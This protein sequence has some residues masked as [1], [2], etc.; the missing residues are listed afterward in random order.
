MKY[1]SHCGVQVFDEA[2]VCPNCGCAIASK[3]SSLDLPSTGLNI[4]SFL[5]PLVGL[6]L[7]I[8]YNDK[9]PMKAKAIGKWGIIGFIAN[10]VLAAII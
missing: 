4:L 8:M 5:I 7:F 10:V 1:C 3:D 6:I 9:F 2:V